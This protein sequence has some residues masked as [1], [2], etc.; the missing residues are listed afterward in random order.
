M[1]NKTGIQE[2]REKTTRAFVVSKIFS[3]P[4]V[5]MIALEKK[6]KKT[7]RIVH[8]CEFLVPYRFRGI[9]GTGM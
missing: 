4:L 5:R 1:I 7:S 2:S 8:S 9:P 6:K 3:P